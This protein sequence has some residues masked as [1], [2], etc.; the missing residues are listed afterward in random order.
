MYIHFGMSTS[1]RF[2]AHA[3]FDLYYFTVTARWVT[4]A[5]H[6]I[7]QLGLISVHI[8]PNL[9]IPYRCQVNPIHSRLWVLLSCQNI[10]CQAVLSMFRVVLICR[11]ILRHSIFP[12]G[13]G[14]IFCTWHNAGLRSIYL[15][16]CYLE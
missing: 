4:P 16:N 14:H 1:K 12:P 8:N 15:H 6:L 10:C 9:C 11:V 3:S 13:I 2:A 7:F 5:L